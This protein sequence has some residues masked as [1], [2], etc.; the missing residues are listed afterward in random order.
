MATNPNRLN[1]VVNIAIL[2]TL[3]ILLMG[4]AGPGRRWYDGWR[5]GAAERETVRSLW[6][7]MIDQATIISSG[8]GSADT[9]V[10]F[11]DYE[12]PFCRQAETELREP[13]RNGLVIALLHLPLVTLHD[14]AW[15]AASA[16]LE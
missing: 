11:S 7:E 16:A 6:G 12:C 4:P 3:A 10:M 2:T 5:G 13:V 8:S 15:E 1:I 14:K 9:V